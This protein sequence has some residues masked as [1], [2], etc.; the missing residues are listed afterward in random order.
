MADPNLDKDTPVVVPEL[1][2]GDAKKEDVLK[3]SAG[4]MQIMAVM[5]STAKSGDV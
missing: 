3:V 1:V 4:V 5:N 2:E